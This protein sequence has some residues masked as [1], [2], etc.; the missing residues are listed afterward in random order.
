MV[1]AMLELTGTILPAAVMTRADLAAARAARGFM[2]DAEGLLLHRAG[3]AAAAHGPMLEVGSYCGKSAV[4]L[5]AA[6]RQHSSVLFSVDH[7][8]GSEEN[9]PGEQYCDREVVDAATGRL[10]T[11]PHFRRTLETAGLEEWVIAVVGTSAAVARHWSTP[12]SLL[13]IDGGHSEH[14][15]Q[16]DYAGFHGRLGDGG[17]LLIHD[18]FPDPA[19]GGRAPFH[20]YLRALDDGFREVAVEGSLRVLAR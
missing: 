16:A 1:G 19:N 4:Y 6:A 10:D 13:F 8:R 15:A 12:L 9:Q 3:V 14:A 17:L 11:L 18:V 5:G 7:H 2:P 20:V